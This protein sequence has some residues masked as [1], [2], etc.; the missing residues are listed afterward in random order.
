MQDLE[1]NTIFKMENCNTIKEQ[2]MTDLRP[3]KSQT[4]QD[5]LVEIKKA[6]MEEQVQGVENNLQDRKG[7]SEKQPMADINTGSTDNQEQVERSVDEI[8]EGE[9]IDE[10][11]ATVDSLSVDEQEPVTVSES[12]LEVSK[13]TQM[14]EDVLIPIKSEMSDNPN[15]A[16]IIE[17]GGS[18]LESMMEIKDH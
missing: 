2:E 8:E 15:Q 11:E 10:M 9:I 6:L 16:D 17:N 14:E 12:N 1:L 18:D 5:D 4:Y 13:V 3:S 7:T